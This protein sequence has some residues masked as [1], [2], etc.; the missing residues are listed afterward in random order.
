MLSPIQLVLFASLPFIPIADSVPKFDMAA[1]CPSEGGSKAMLEK[2]IE[3]ESAARDQLQPLWI[4]ARF[5]RS[6]D[7]AF[8][9]CR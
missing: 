4:L 2:C 3:D 8:G 6:P 7:A 1:E 9:L 5:R